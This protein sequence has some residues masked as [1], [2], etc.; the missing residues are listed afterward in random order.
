MGKYL[1]ENHMGGVYTSDHSLPWDSLYCE[2]CGDSDWELGFAN[3]RKE[4]RKLLKAQDYTEEYIREFLDKEFPKKA[5][6]RKKKT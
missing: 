1:Y 3:N 6:E 5:K 2:T 4:A